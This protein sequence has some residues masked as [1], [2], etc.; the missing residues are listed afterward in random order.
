MI[1]FKRY[2]TKEDADYIQ[3][4]CTTGFETTFSALYDLNIEKKYLFVDDTKNDSLNNRSF[5]L[6]EILY[7]S[8]YTFREFLDSIYN[9]LGVNS[10]TNLVIH[11][12]ID[13]NLSINIDNVI[14]NL[15]EESNKN[16]N[17]LTKLEDCLL[18]GC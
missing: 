16:S 1:I 5:A 7:N 13:K 15:T 8:G 3:L 11:Y 6:E 9:C 14:F 17:F 2:E 18:N 12:V 4:V 10:K